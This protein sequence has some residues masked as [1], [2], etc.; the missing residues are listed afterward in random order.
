MLSEVVKN[1]CDKC[2]K[3][4]GIMEYICKCEKRFC[5]SHLQAEEHNCIYDYKKEGKDKIKRENDVGPLSI[6]IDKI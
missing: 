4:L 5:I 2:K 1:R 6:K 3:K